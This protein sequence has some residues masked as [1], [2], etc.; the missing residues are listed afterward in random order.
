MLLRQRR[1]RA[2]AGFATHSFLLT[3]AVEGLGER[4]ADI[5]RDFTR[6]LALGNP[7]P[8]FA[9]SNLYADLSPALQPAVVAD[10]EF[11][12]FAA[13]SFDLIVSAL[14]LHVVNDLPG[15]LLQIRRAL[16]PDGF[17][18]GVM[19]GGATLQE[20]RQVLLE[21]ESEIRGGAAPRIA[22]FADLRDMAG[23]LQRAGF[24]LPVAD[25]ET[26][27]VTYPDLFALL[28]DLRGMAATGILKA[29]PPLS[30]KTLFHAAALYQQRFGAAGKIPATFQLIHLAGWNL[31]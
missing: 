4:L 17:F 15:A 6:V 22:P 20:L 8:G 18:L 9:P 26:V 28:K 30:R 3:H 27:T 31:A 25:V 7:L 19:S 16:A 13:G 5:K 23:L 21:A 1:A 10:E 11:L 2:A 24:H 14:A 12:P 29:R